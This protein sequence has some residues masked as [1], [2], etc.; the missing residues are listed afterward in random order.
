MLTARAAPAAE[1]VA[2]VGTAGVSRWSRDTNDEPLFYA[3]PAPTTMS[4]F[5][6]DNEIPLAYLITIRTYGTWLPGDD[7]GSIDRHHNTYG[8]ARV[9]PNPIREEQCR[10]KLKSEPLILDLPK[11]VAVE[12]GIVEVCK[13][14]DWLLRAINVRTNHAHT[15]IS[16]GLIDPSRALNA[17]KAYGT[18]K[19]RER[20]LW[21]H[22][23]SPWAERGSKR[24]LWTET[25]VAC[26]CDYVINGQGH[27]LRDFDDRLKNRK[28]N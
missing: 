2:Q 15:V 8:G 14:R 3:A 10:V 4:A 17:F 24:W 22:Q 13:K 26:A 6:N 1:L 16:I 12:D 9:P 20:G 19:L 21:R 7:R 28:R 27:D 23:H 25:D 5:W 18:R 11:R